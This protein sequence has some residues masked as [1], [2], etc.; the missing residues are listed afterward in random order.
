MGI[1]L[2]LQEKKMVNGKQLDLTTSRLLMTYK[3][4]NSVE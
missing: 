2:L 1:N 3:I 4:A